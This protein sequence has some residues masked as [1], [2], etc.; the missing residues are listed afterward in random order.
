MARHYTELVPEEDRRAAK[1][2]DRLITGNAEPLVPPMTVSSHSLTR[3]YRLRIQTDHQL[4]KESST[5]HRRNA[6]SIRLKPKYPVHPEC[7]NLLCYFKIGSSL[8]I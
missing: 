3:Y 4:Y 6:F 1:H 2:I 7:Y 5:V 8:S